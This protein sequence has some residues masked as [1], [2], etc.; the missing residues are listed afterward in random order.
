MC[1]LQY[2]LSI[3]AL[4]GRKFCLQGHQNAFW[5]AAHASA[6]NLPQLVSLVAVKAS[7]LDQAD[8][9]HL[10]VCF[11]GSIQLLCTSMPDLYWQMAVDVTA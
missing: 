6:F 4:Q 11:A 5:R 1:W 9:A 10:K 2:F 8:L 3:N 7:K